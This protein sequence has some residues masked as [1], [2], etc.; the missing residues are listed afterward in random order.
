MINHFSDVDIILVEGFKDET[1]PK[2]MYHR[3][4]NQKP[5]FI[6]LFT[7]VI[8]FDESIKTNLPA[9]NINEPSQIAEFIK[10]Y[11]ELTM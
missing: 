10:S 2:I 9:L 1:I 5:L 3:S 6:D 4:A 7:I 8:A 11:F